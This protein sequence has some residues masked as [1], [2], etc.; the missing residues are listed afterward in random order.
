MYSKEEILELTERVYVTKRVKDILLKEQ[1]RLKGS[2]TKMSLAKIV[3]NLIIEKY[4]R[5]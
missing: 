5:N 1:K 3:C 2:D 4:E